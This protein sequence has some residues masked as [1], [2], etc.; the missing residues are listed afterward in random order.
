MGKVY[1]GEEIFR[2]LLKGKSQQLEG[3]MKNAIKQVERMV[4]TK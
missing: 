2:T 3:N 4:G 1:E